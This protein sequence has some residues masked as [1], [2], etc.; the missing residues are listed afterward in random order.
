[1]QRKKRLVALAAAAMLLAAWSTFR[2]GPAGEVLTAAEA[3][4]GLIELFK[5]PPDPV[6]GEFI[7]P[8]EDSVAEPGDGPDVV[9]FGPCQCNLKDR[10]FE[11]T[12]DSPEL[13]LTCSGRFRPGADG[14]WQA[15]SDNV[16]RSC[17]GPWEQ[18]A[19]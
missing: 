10:T 13:F 11:L 19:R 16:L 3:K 5:H 8:L 2:S 17:H 18:A 9:S 14:N 15:V 6:L 4:A 12:I 7:K 1:M